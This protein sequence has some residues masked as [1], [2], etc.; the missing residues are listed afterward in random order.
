[1]VDRC[2]IGA[3]AAT[4]RLDRLE[5]S[6]DGLRTDVARFRQIFA[7]GL[8]TPAN[9]PETWLHADLHPRNVLTIAGH[10]KGVIDW[11]DMCAGDPC[12]DLA[13]AWLFFEPEDHHAIWDVY[14][15]TTQL[16]D[17]ARAWTVAY[18]V[19]LLEAGMGMDP[20]LEAAGR[21]ALDRILR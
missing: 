16:L 3:G 14:E 18:G 1:M 4:A 13:A 11:G 7:H 21:A 19:M 17:R 15:P 12:T 5:Q 8:E 10:M 2:G 20:R 6:D 9:E